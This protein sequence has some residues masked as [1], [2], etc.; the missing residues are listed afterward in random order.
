[1]FLSQQNQVLMLF[2]LIMIDFHNICVFEFT[3]IIIDFHDTF[4][5]LP[6]NS[7][8]VIEIKFVC[9]FKILFV[10]KST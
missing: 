10:K 5:S 1:M 2:T 8:A 7:F 4:Q 9:L 3:L 6:K